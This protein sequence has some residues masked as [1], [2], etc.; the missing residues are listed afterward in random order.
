MSVSAGLLRQ[1]TIRCLSSSVPRDNSAG[2]LLGHLQ[3]WASK[4]RLVPPTTSCGSPG[5]CSE[6]CLLHLPIF[7]YCLP[8]MEFFSTLFHISGLGTVLSSR[9]QLPSTGMTSAAR[10]ETGTSASLVSGLFCP[11]LSAVLGMPCPHSY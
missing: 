7:P 3:L 1:P 2:F 5:P 11:A 10:P 8:S 4:H 6:T 9:H